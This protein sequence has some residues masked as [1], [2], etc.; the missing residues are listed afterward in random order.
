MKSSELYLNSFSHIYVERDVF[1]YEKT[2]DIL[3][4]VVN[5]QVIVIDNY[6]DV[7]NRPKQDFLLQ[8]KSQKLIL[9]KKEM[10]SYTRALN[11]VKTLDINISFIHQIF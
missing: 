6:K 10:N 7:F 11:F 9:A 2:T 8:K 4:K 1:E 5:G 3:R